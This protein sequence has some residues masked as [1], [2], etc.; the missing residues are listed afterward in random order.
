MPLDHWLGHS[1]EVATSVRGVLALSTVWDNLIA[2]KVS[3]WPPPELVQKIYQ[4]R[5]RRAFH[6]ADEE[7]ATKHLG[8]YSDLQSVHSED[9][10]TWS[11]FGPLVYASASTRAAF[12]EELLS[13]LGIA[14]AVSSASLWL[15]RRLPHPDNLVPGGPEVDVGI[16]TSSTLILGEAKWRSG[17]GRAQ[18]ITRDKDQIHLRADFCTKYGRALY[19]N[20]S[21]FIVLGIGQREGLLSEAQRAHATDCLSIAEVSWAALAALGSNPF[22]T[23]FRAQLDWRVR[24]SK[25]L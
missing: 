24:H 19:P 16:H 10:V 2:G 25:A 12:V 8:F 23:E 1:V 11:L 14:E 17:V 4:S 20:V 22:A 5:Q 9:A 15:W 6:G 13:L 3:P 18:G 21:R 7:L